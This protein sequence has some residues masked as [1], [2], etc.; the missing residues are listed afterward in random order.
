LLYLINNFACQCTIDNVEPNEVVY[1]VAIKG[2]TQVKYNKGTVVSFITDSQLHQS[3]RMEEAAQ[4][5]DEMTKSSSVPN[6]RTFN[7]LLRGCL[8]WGEV[9]MAES[10]YEIM[11]QMLMEPDISSF[12]YLVK[13]YCQAIQNDNAWN[14]IKKMQTAEVEPTAGIYAA[15]AV[16]CALVRDLE[17]TK[18][19]ICHLSFI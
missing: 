19:V 18:K 4:L 11:E 13:S 1:T 16:S 7:T 6:L 12:E 17:R 9:E 10:V 15:I 3:G 8:R 2:A 14:T 5:L